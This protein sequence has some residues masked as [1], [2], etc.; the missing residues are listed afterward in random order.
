MD[1]AWPRVARRKTSWRG[2]TLVELLV[3]IAI[4]G[5]LIALLL[6]AV[7]AAREAARRSMCSNHVKQIG[8]ALH[9]YH[10]AN[11][12]L[13]YGSGDCCDSSN[14]YAWGGTYPTLILAFLEEQTLSDRIDFKK[15]MQ[16]QS[17]TVLTT[18]IST[19]MCPSDASGSDAILTDR[20]SGHNPNPAMGLWYTASMGPTI[21][22]S[23]VF[24]ASQ[25][26]DPGNYCCQGNNFGTQPG[27][28]TG[29]PVS[30]PPGSSVGM[31]GRYRNA[32]RF[33]EVLDGLSKTLM[34]G[35]TLPR[36]CIFIS[37]FAVNFTVS[38][39]TIP[40]N[41]MQNDGG[42]VTNWWL[43]SGF[44]SRHP[45]GVNVC[46]ADGSVQFLT[47]DID[48]KLYNNLGTRAGGEV[49]SLP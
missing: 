2:F 32:V 44:K 8:V 23:C 9:N 46:M 28:A 24:C 10:D 49:V 26:S 16:Q 36:D 45:A 19:Y 30:Y 11:K 47:E 13:P 29:G 15:H 1:L 6:P 42:A 27:N 40:I 35:E 41:N 3:V 33:R 37:T 21:P 43:S 4:I 39:T 20:Y 48:Y 25:I 12:T 22:D 38:T 5:I 34:V 7:Q 18:I 14:P 31:F 17:P